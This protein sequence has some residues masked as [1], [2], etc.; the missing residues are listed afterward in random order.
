MILEYKEIG[1]RI[2]ERRK[3][4]KISQQA[5]AEILGISNNHLSGLERGK[6]GL[7]LEVLVGICNALKVTPDFLLMGSMHSGNLPKN[8]CGNLELCSDKDLELFYKISCLM[9]DRNNEQ[10]NADNFM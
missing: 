8:I 2:A 5:L 6:A 7:S 4:Q 3:Q 1:R 9:V 10:W